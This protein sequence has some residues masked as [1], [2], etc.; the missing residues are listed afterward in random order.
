VFER[1]KHENRLIIISILLFG[2]SFPINSFGECIK[3]DCVNGKGVYTFSDERKYD[4]E[5]ING[6]FYK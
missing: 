1:K 6:E 3:G 5:W 4:G 2:L